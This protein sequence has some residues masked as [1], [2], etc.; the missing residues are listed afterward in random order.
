MENV[1]N[2]LAFETIEYII[3]LS[4]IG[5]RP[6]HIIDHGALF[7]QRRAWKFSNNLGN[8]AC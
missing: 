5:A 4:K 7:F 8:A 6:F 1:K 3:K 2:S